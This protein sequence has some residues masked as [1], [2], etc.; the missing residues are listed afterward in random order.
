M[1]RLW[2]RW[3]RFLAIRDTAE[4][5]ALCRILCGGGLVLSI[6]LVLP[7]GAINELWVDSDHG[8][9]RQLGD[10]WTPDLAWG[11]AVLAMLAGGAL[12][13]G[14]H[15]QITAFVGLITFNTI[16]HINFHDGS[17]YDSLLTNQ[18]FLLIWVNSGATWSLDAR[19]RTGKWQSGERVLMWPRYVMILQLVLCYWSTGVQKI[20]GHWLPG[21]D[22]SA[23]WY[24]LQDPFWRRWDLTS[25]MSGMYLLTQIG[26]AVT[27]WFEVLAPLLLLAF[28]YRATRDRQG[29]VR[30]IFNRIDF[31]SWFAVVGILFHV[32]IHVF[33]RVG[34]FSWIILSYYPALWS[35]RE[36]RKRFRS[37]P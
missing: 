6:L 23:L 14:W 26:T 16:I 18:L 3:L 30:G 7:S 10:I 37:R 9:Y 22:S 4:P 13:L 34:P 11:L 25:E 15:S 29:K 33:M 36:Y 32:G 20:S 21:G 12:A 27:W 5:L 8:G 31:R 28:W 17:A 24:V 1:I 35:S 19:R 2:Q